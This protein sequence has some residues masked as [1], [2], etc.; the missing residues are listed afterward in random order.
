MVGE[1]YCEWCGETADGGYGHPY[2]QAQLVL[3]G[4]PEDPRLE[5][6]FELIPVEPGPTK[7]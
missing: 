7:P 2:C 1:K 4:S 5:G 6:A 3:M